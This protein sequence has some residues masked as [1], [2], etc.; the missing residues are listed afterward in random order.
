MERK[1]EKIGNVELNFF[2]Y[3]G[4]DSYTD[5]DLIENE[6]LNIVKNTPK[7][8]FEEI[9][10][11]KKKW[12]ILY[13]LSDI[14]T[15]VLEWVPIKKDETVLEIG[16]GCGAITTIL[17]EKAKKV[18][19][20]ELSKKRSLINAYRNKKK[21][22]IEIIV[23]NFQDIEIN[24]KYDYIT[25]IGVF[26]YASSYIDSENPHDKLLEMIKK[27]LKPNGKIII[28]IENKI[29]MK[30]WAG[31]KEDHTGIY[32]EGLQDYPN[33]DV[34]KTFTKKEL[35]SL[36]EK[37]GFQKNDF[38]YPYPD[39][40]FPST[41]YSDEYLPKLGELSNNI[42]N[43]DDDRLFLFDETEANN[44][45][46]KAGLFSEFSNS[47]IVLS[48]VN[49][50]ETIEE[51][52]IFSKYSVSRDRKFR[53]RTSIF[54]NYENEKI[55]RKFALSKEGM[56]HLKKISENYELLKDQYKNSEFNIV[57]C[58]KKEDYLEFDY[59]N[60]KTLTELF[61]ELAEKNTNN[62]I[63]EV[64]MIKNELCQMSKGEIFNSN[65]KEFENIFG[66]VEFNDKIEVIKPANIDF[67][68][69]NIIINDKINIIDYEWVF[70]FSVPINYIIYRILLYYENENIN[71]KDFNLK[72]ILRELDITENEEE[73]YWEMDRN[74]TNYVL[75]KGYFL[76]DLYLQFDIKNI[77][78]NDILHYKEKLFLDRTVQVFKDT[79]KGYSEEE[80][81]RILNKLSSNRMIELEIEV[82]K[83]IKNLRI[84]PIED[85]CIIVIRE[86]QQNIPILSNGEKIYD[87]VFLF[88]NGDPQIII[89]NI[90][91][92]IEKI[93]LKIEILSLES[94]LVNL[95]KNIENKSEEISIINKEKEKLLLEILN[96]DNEIQRIIN[97]K[98]YRI[99]KFVKKLLFWRK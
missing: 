59:V 70:N 46:M 14:R 30:Y 40:K 22:N 18:T 50:Q 75:K 38:Y 98:G 57:E 61:N 6:I 96:K 37:N 99:V 97:S 68:G 1:I 95:I 35:K 71:K 67:I 63:K 28:A 53:I 65:S 48:Q 32:F 54:K 91:S 88:K 55:V 79:G 83:N 21:E 42:R 94:S 47:F 89:N 5:G 20:I 45:I 72:T 4:V 7:E 84:D 10:F 33:T 3:N 87:N 44:T 41:I 39:Y 76:H 27:Y 82:S 43:F 36:L 49:N 69:S 17:S 19:C 11:D 62:I 26:E 15:N 2:F 9:I 24:E 52:N 8:K 74:F 60:G 31:C 90:S 23:G 93:Q 80:S 25:M 77:K 13:H 12:P 92:D 73:K 29:G 34:V 58:R 56:D 51:K 78:L 64:R 66:K 81:Y 16:S 86:N 85:K